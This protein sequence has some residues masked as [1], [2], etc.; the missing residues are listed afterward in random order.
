MLPAFLC[1]TSQGR[2]THA[3][4]QLGLDASKITEVFGRDGN[5]AVFAEAQVDTQLALIIEACLKDT[6]FS[7]Q[8]LP[9]VM[10]TMTGTRAGDP[11]GST[12][13]VLCMSVILNK[14]HQELVNRELVVF[15][16]RATPTTLAGGEFLEGGRSWVVAAR[17]AAW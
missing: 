12:L 9:S 15:L 7:T 1:A 3:I 14:V 4:E 11:F 13:F 10:S 5:G 16:Q 6:W 17:D 2:Y 8:G